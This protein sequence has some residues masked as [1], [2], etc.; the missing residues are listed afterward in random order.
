MQRPRAS[1][2]WGL[3][4]PCR[5]PPGARGNTSGTRPAPTHEA[6]GCAAAPAGVSPD[7]RSLGGA[8][9]PVTAA[10]AWPTA[11]RPPPPPPPP[12]CSAG[13]SSL[14]PAAAV[15]LRRHS[16]KERTRA[17]PGSARG[18]RPQLPAASPSRGLSPAPGQRAGRRVQRRAGRRPACAERPE[19][20]TLCVRARVCACVCASF[21]FSRGCEWLRCWLLP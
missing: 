9:A 20:R 2:A 11:A 21:P 6:E 12:Y 1:P 13:R 14:G 18:R 8:A 10:R 16:G 7:S 17:R 19:L 15:A 4:G 5:P 3:P